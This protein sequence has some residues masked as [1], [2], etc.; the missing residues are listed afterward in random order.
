[1]KDPSA[2]FASEVDRSVLANAA[3]PVIHPAVRLFNLVL[4]DG[5]VVLTRPRLG[6]LFSCPDE[7]KQSSV[8]ARGRRH[9]GSLEPAALDFGGPLNERTETY[10]AR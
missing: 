10:A 9:S 7:K 8:Q 4:V 6:A 5:H 2:P 1:M 3:I